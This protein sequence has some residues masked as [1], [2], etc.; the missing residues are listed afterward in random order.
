MLPATDSARLVHS[1]TGRSS[2]DQGE[3]VRTSE[4]RYLAGAPQ[5]APT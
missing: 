5:S 4:Q 3:R 1:E 2:I